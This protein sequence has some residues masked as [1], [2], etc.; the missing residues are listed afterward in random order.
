[1][2]GLCACLSVAVFV[3]CTKLA[4]GCAGEF[5]LHWANRHSEEMFCFENVTGVWVYAMGHCFPFFVVLC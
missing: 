4:V 5:Y 1:M 3:F 2:W